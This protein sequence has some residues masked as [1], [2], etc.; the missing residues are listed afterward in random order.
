MRDG[1]R[2]S[3][4]AG[5]RAN[6]FVANGLGQL[7]PWSVVPRLDEVR[8][9]SFVF[10]FDHSF[11]QGRDDASIPCERLAVLGIGRVQYAGSDRVVRHHVLAAHLP[12][13]DQQGYQPPHGM[14]KQRHGTGFARVVVEQPS[15]DRDMLFNGVG[16][17]NP[18]LTVPVQGGRNHH[19]P[20]GT[21]TYG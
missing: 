13:S 9:T 18:G 5:R 14:T 2:L 3:G 11:V 12:L 7:L 17:T 16:A 10:A 19:P 6:E 4:Q 8:N 1:V 20:G 15:Y 21:E